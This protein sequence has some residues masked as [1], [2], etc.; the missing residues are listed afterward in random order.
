MKL[1]VKGVIA[2]LVVIGSFGIVGT[3]YVAFGRAPDHDVL[4]FSSAALMLVLGYFFGHINGTQTALTNSAVAL[5]Q[6]AMEKRAAPAV[7][8][9]PIAVSA[10]SQPPGPAPG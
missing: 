8:T 9:L 3:P 4:L 10:P 5:A 2:I 1:D 6:Q 7:V